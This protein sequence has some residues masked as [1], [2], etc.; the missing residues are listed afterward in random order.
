MLGI[1]RGSSPRF[2]LIHIWITSKVG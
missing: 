1:Q 2:P